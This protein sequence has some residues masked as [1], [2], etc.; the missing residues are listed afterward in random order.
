MD[1]GEIL[2]PQFVFFFSFLDGRYQPSTI[3]ANHVDV[4]WRVDQRWFVYQL[5]GMDGSSIR[6]IFWQ[7]PI[8]FMNVSS[9]F[10]HF[11]HK[12]WNP[13]LSSS[14]LFPSFLSS[15]FIPPSLL[16][17]H[18]GNPKK[19]RSKTLIIAS[20]SSV[21]GCQSLHLFLTCQLHW[22]VSLIHGHEHQ[23]ENCPH[24]QRPRTSAGSPAMTWSRRRLYFWTGV[25]GFFD[26]R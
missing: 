15:F 11:F 5:K 9:V 20:S 23:P 8:W 4:R 21:P 22:H 16:N 1:T 25:V 3:M 26:Q 6:L 2:W 12:F 10:K 17:P 18:K 7:N 19:I 24:A 14:G 13:S